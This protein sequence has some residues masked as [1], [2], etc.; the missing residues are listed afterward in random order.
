MKLKKGVVRWERGS[1]RMRRI[2][3]DAAKPPSRRSAGIRDI[4]VIR[5]GIDQRSYSRP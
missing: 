2:Y 4:R 5:D 1:M 3:A